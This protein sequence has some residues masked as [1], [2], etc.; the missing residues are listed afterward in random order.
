[1]PENYKKISHKDIYNMFNETSNE[2]IKELALKNVLFDI[3]HK[4][5]N[6]KC[7]RCQFDDKKYELKTEFWGGKELPCLALLSKRYENIDKDNL[8]LR[9]IIVDKNVRNS[10]G[11][12]VSTIKVVYGIKEVKK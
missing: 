10:G 12:Y 4:P 2:L 9:Q 1:M 8:F 6:L 7:G 11:D 5:E 3:D